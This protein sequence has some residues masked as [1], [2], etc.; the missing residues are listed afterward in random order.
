MLELDVDELKAEVRRLEQVKAQMY[1]TE[2]CENQYW[3]RILGARRMFAKNLPD[4]K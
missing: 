2:Q 1:T 3:E 4:F